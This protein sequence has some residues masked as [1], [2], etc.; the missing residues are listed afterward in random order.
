MFSASF[1]SELHQKQSNQFRRSIQE[2]SWNLDLNPW[3]QKHRWWCLRHTSAKLLM[4]RLRL[5]AWKRLWP[6]YA[7]PYESNRSSTSASVDAPDYYSRTRHHR[8]CL[9]S[10]DIHPQLHLASHLLPST[11]T[12]QSSGYHDFS[13]VICTCFR[14]TLWLSTATSPNWST[15]RD[16]LH[17][18]CYT[19][20]RNLYLR[21]C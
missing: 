15:S 14:Q 17:F 6:G 9:H 8:R 18:H 19:N 20:W 10:A 2:F 1:E 13:K 21:K 11:R 3:N 12:D 4:F 7:G 16:L 5:A